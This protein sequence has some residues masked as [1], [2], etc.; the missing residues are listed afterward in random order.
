HCAAMCGPLRLFVA[1]H[2]RGRLLYQGGR[3]LSYVSIGVLAGAAGLSLPA[4]SSL[5]LLLLAAVLVAFP[6]AA[7]KIRFPGQSKL[8]ALAASNLLLLGA[9]SALLPCG[10]LHAWIAAAAATRSP[11]AGGAIL[12]CLWLGSAPAL[13]LAPTL[14]KGWLPNIRARFWFFCPRALAPWCSG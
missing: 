2:P 14:L 3:G 7:R 1:E 5:P 9:S 8:M 12:A 6:K 4:W 13:E 10:L 11:W